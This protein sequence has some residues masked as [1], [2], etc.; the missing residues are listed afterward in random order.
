MRLLLDSDVFCKLSIGGVLVDAV[1][2]LGGDLSDCRRLPA[3]PH[4]LR[5]GSLRRAYGQE[6]CDAVIP[7]AERISA[8]EPPDISW[9]DKLTQIPA[10]DAGEAQLFAAVA[11]TGG[12]IATGDK[13]ALRALREI[14]GFPEALAGRVVVCEAILLVLCE[15][16]G[17][18]IVRQRMQ[19]I[20]ASDTV[21]RI[22]FSPGNSDPRS[23]LVS[24]YRNLVA[25]LA[26][27]T[28]WSPLSEGD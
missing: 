15:H 8:I 12:F 23:C 14:A 3:L 5:K 6:A 27:L 22:C 9:L 13:R 2:V 28:L 4:M 20:L 16:L 19:P 1:S 26:P 24:Y 7:V 21:I 18:E 17:T 25:E 11:E 10:I